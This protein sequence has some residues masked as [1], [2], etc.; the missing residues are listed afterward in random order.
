MTERALHEYKDKIL[1]ELKDKG[2]TEYKTTEDLL[3]LYYNKINFF[4]LSHISE[5]TYDSHKLQIVKEH[6]GYH[7]G[8]KN[9]LEFKLIPIKNIR[10]E[11]L[12]DDKKIGDIET[13]TGLINHGDNI[14]NESKMSLQRS[15]QNVEMTKVVAKEIT[16]KIQANTEAMVRI[17]NDLDEIDAPI[18]R[19][20][21]ILIRI[22]RRIATDKYIWLCT[23]LVFLA[24]VVI[25]LIHTKVIPSSSI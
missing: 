6:L 4:R 19:S 8:L 9:E 11:L 3:K 22:G 21:K 14:L 12:G 10:K 1:E 20:K 16:I 18:N 13:E 24:I 17:K 7:E 15:V 23:G 2:R 5:G 25:I